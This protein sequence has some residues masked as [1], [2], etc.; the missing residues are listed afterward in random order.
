MSMGVLLAVASSA[1]SSKRTPW[2]TPDLNGVWDSGTLTPLERPSAMSDREFLTE[3]E[4]E[5]IRG[6]GVERALKLA[7]GTTEGK[8]T[9]EISDIWLGTPE[10]VVRSL[11][12]SLIID[13]PDGRIP[14][15]Q[16]GRRR[17]MHQLFVFIAPTAPT[18]GPEVRSLANRCLAS[19]ALYEPNPLYLN[20]HSIVQAEDYVAIRSELME[21]RIIRL[22]GPP[23]DPQI[24]RWSGVSR[25]HWE[26]DTLVVETT[27][28]NGKGN[29]FG[30]TE[31]L[32]VVEH[33]TLV[34]AETI[35]YRVTFDDPASFTRPWTTE[36]T[37]R[38]ME[39]PI[40]EFACHEGNYALAHILRAARL[41]EREA[42]ESEAKGN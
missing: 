24:R 15:T 8:V 25:G 16:E 38:A 5:A 1:E 36:N 28:F 27:N 11:R 9:G 17:R 18:D 35:D 37:L 30:S 14:Y 7:E 26:G 34:D 12:T 20:Y 3:E 22:G 42:A 23:P 2:G 21:T 39:P 33:F 10:E 6:T 32:R 13:P 29:Y 31:N 4:A 41:E 19:G 40:Y